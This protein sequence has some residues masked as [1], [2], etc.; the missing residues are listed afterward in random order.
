LANAV[1]PH[2]YRA[3]ETVYH[4]GTPALALYC[5]RSGKLKLFRRLSRGEEVVVGVR[6]P[7][8]LLGLRSL[9]TQ[10]SHV[11]TAMTLEPGVVCA[12]PGVA[13]LGRVRENPKKGYR[14]LRQVASESHLLE[15]QLVERT[16]NRVVKRTAQ[17]LIE[18]IQLQAAAASKGD[19]ISI[20]M[21]REEMAQL[22]GTTPETLSRTLHGL[23]TE[24]ILAVERREI[25]VLDLAALV[26]LSG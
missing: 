1:V 19:R 24:G 12:L 7:G 13:F 5:V 21:N 8:D 4:A 9:L 17:F 26:E 6:G 10:S 22:I 16:H 14:L 2:M 3:H 18:Q 23:A 15:E 25:R 20:A 11:T